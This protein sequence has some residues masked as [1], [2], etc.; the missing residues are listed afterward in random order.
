MGY[1]LR[2]GEVY[3][4]E[5]FE[6]TNMPPRSERHGLPKDSRYRHPPIG[7]TAPFLVFVTSV[8]DG[9]SSSS[10]PGMLKRGFRERFADFHP[11]LPLGIGGRK[12]DEDDVVCWEFN[13]LIIGCGP[14]WTPMNTAHCSGG[15]RSGG[16]CRSCWNF[17]LIVEALL[18]AVEVDQLCRGWWVG[19]M[20]QRTSL[21]HVMMCGI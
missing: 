3:Y 4:Q 18:M 11:L 13:W 16:C 17:V 9:A 2:E 20:T 15:A 5:G 6:P 8:L 21:N 12:P 1:L 7:N 14:L 10:L 19:W